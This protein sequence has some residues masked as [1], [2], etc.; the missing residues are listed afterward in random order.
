[1]NSM[2]DAFGDW[3]NKE[4]IQTML[5]AC[6]CMPECTFY[7]LTKNPKRY[8]EKGIQ[9]F[10][11]INKNFWM[12]FTA[13]TGELYKERWRQY[14][15]PG[16]HFVSIEPI[17]DSRHVLE[18]DGPGEHPKWVIIGPRTNPI[19]L[20]Y[21]N[22]VESIFLQCRFLGI[23]IFM[24]DKLAPLYGGKENLI[25]EIPEVNNDQRPENRTT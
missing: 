21:K 17:F 11:K 24:K 7:F 10:F 14:P 12:G 23:P 20:P 15:R 4:W 25:Q 18:Q 1:M 3:I 9:E 13:E 19:K 22:Q 2:G 5:A 8:F 6:S 16:N